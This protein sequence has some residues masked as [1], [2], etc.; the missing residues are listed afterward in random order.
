MGIVV[1]IIQ[2]MLSGTHSQ[3]HYSKALHSRLRTHLFDTYY[4]AISSEDVTLQHDRNEYFIINE[5]S[6]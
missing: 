1:S 3:G 5:W 4:V 2:H 6:K